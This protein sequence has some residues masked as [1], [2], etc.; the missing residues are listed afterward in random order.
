M[1][2]WR[3]LLVSV[4]VLSGCYLL[5]DLE[6]GFI[7]I[8]DTGD[9]T[10]LRENGEACTRDGQ[11]I[12]GHCDNDICCPQNRVCCDEDELCNGL[13]ANLACDNGP[14]G[15]FSCFEDC[16]SDGT[17]QIDEQCREGSHC[18][19]SGCEPNVGTGRCDEDSDCSS[20][21]C[22]DAPGFCCEHAGLCCATDGDCPDLFD[23]CATDDTATCVFSLFNLPGTGQTRCFRLSGADVDCDTIAEDHDFYGQDGHGPARDRELVG[24]GGATIV[25]TVTGLTWTADVVGPMNW[26]GAESHCEDLS[27]PAGD[28]RLPTRFELM[29]LVD[30]GGDG[31]FVVDGALFES[32]GDTTHIWSA[33]IVATASDRAWSLETTSGRLVQRSVSSSAHTICV[34]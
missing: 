16:T 31:A 29:T 21:E 13:G 5:A 4:S 34:E 8:E 33:G 28:W 12:L 7:P 30:F 25:D 6:P 24:D 2:V 20:G 1:A 14:G 23:G 11:C 32:I 26:D 17:T 18:E 27:D 9:T 19:L 22:P 3:I 10:P 15:T